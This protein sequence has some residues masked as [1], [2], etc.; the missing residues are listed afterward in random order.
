M[1]VSG[2]VTT[3]DVPEPARL[4][5]L[6]MA[7]PYV[8]SLGATITRLDGG[9]AYLVDD[10]E[11]GTS[12]LFVYEPEPSSSARETPFVSLIERCMRNGWSFRVWW[13]DNSTDAYLNT[14]PVRSIEEVLDNIEKDRYN[15]SWH[16]S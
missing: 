16:A 13:A 9:P 14:R 4:V 10:G 8:A 3:A 15:V 2:N 5:P 12:D 1:T 7:Q 6:P 11:T